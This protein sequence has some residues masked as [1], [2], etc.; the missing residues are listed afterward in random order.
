MNI[1][2]IIK[3]VVSAAAEAEVGALFVNSR[4]VIPAQKKN[5]KKLVTYNP[6]ANSN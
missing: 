6:N 2:H 1:A 4:Q 3:S 5:P